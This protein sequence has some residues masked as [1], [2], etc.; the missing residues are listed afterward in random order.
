[1]RAVR[2]KQMRRLAAQAIGPRVAI[3]HPTKMFGVGIKQ[4]TRMNKRAW[5]RGALK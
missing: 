4:L 1:M 5:N 2:A 3:W